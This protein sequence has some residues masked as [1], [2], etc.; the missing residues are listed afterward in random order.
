MITSELLTE[1]HEMRLANPCS[2]KVECIKRLFIDGKFNPEN[3]AAGDNLIISVVG[4][5]GWTHKPITEI[6][7]RK[8]IF[9][10]GEFQYIIMS[11]CY[12]D[13]KYHLACIDGT[14]TYLFIT[15]TSTST[16]ESVT[17]NSKTMTEEDYLKILNM[18][19]VCGVDFGI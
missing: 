12:H 3:W 13:N 6:Y 17:K 14:D 5:H 15:S 7:T 18:L 11:M 16:L 2:R 9:D 19:Q 4:K 1:L 8:N 10:D